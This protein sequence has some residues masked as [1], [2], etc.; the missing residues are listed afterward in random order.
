[1]AKRCCPRV[2]PAFIRTLLSPIASVGT[3]WILDSGFWVDTRVWEDTNIWI[4]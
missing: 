3:N 1:M 2:S 4:D